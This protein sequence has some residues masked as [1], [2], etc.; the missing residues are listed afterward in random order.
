MCLFMKII[1]RAFLLIIVYSFILASNASAQTPSLPQKLP[2]NTESNVPQNMN[3]Y[4]QSV[5]IN[6]LS[7]A[8]CFTTG[9]DPLTTDGKCLEVN[10]ITKK[11]GYATE[12][13]GGLLALTGNLIGSTYNIPVSTSE[14]GRTVAANFGITKKT[15]AQ[16]TPDEICSN[17]NLPPDEVASCLE[18]VRAQQGGFGQGI[19]FKGL[20]P[21][22][23]IWETF[24]NIV[25][26]LFV[27]VFLLL[28][29]GIMF[30]VNIDARTVMTIQNQIPKIVIAL[31]LITLSYAIAGFLIDMMYISIYLVIQLFDS[32]GLT[33]ITNIDTNPINAV[34]R[35]GGISSIATPAAQGVGG[36]ISSLFDGTIGTFISTAVTTIVGT[37]VGTGIAPG[38]GSIIGSALGLLGGL[39]FGNQIIGFVATAIAYLIIVIAILSTLFRV[40][41]MLIKAYVFIIL[42]VVFAPFWILKGVIPGAGGGFG[43]WI[44]SITSNLAAFPVVIV[45]FLI[46]KAVQENVV[47]GQQTFIPPLVGDP[48]EN[49]VGAIGSI[50]GLGMILI[51]P[52]AVNI[53]KQALKAPDLKIAGAAGRAIGV[54]QEFVSKP[55]GNTWKALTEERRDGSRGILRSTF[56]EGVA[57]AAEKTGLSDTRIGRWYRGRK[58]EEL[59]RRYAHLSPPRTETTTGG[60]GGNDGDQS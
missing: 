27:L 43:P 16:Q 42:D 1:I 33:T 60:D 20:T 7:T 37:L 31:V 10:P 13:Q 56:D 2:L 11:L 8:S 14:Y 59:K 24:R 9:F 50:I 46:G 32:Q 48:G 35:F 58:A 21:V 22:L 57:K 54:G 53:T 52:E 29:L 36:M 28:G 6:M 5:F 45:L 19:G 51:M 23:K 25:Y 49:G 26:L 38:V 41:F 4:T 39:F 44:R 18:A 3:T 17:Q 15:Y 34:G 55:I 40:W 12:G 47:S 30:R